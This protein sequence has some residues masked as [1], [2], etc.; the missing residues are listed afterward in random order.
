MDKECGMHRM[1]RILS[2][3]ILAAMA[4]T[5]VVGLT[6]CGGTGLDYD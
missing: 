5:A 3:V 6:S 2:L 1:K 4:V